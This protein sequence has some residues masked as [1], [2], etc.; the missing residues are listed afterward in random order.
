MKFDIVEIIDNEDQTATLIVDMDMEYIKA[1]AGMKLREIL[2][3]AANTTLVL[4]K[5]DS[6]EDNKGEN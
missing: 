6:T 1:L 4:N 3:E 2:L 5:S